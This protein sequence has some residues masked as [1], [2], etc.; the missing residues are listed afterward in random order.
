[1][2][3]FSTALLKSRSRGRHRSGAESSGAEQRA[4]GILKK[5]EHLLSL[6]KQRNASADLRLELAHAKEASARKSEAQ[7]ALYR[8]QSASYAARCNPAQPKPPPWRVSLESIA[9]PHLQWHAA[10][11]L[12][13]LEPLESLEPHDHDIQDLMAGLMRIVEQGEQLG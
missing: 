1:M 3:R 5:A 13:P 10:E 11:P 9:Q 8:D 7:A 4:A 2:T 12:E 6:A